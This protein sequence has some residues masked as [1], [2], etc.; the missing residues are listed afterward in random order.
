M[1]DKRI[2][3]RVRARRPL[4]SARRKGRLTVLDFYLPHCD[5]VLRT[6]AVIHARPDDT[7]TWLKRFDFAQL[8]QPVGRAIEGMRAVPRPVAAVA[9]RAR[10]VPSTARFLLDD[11]LRAGFI[12]LSEDRGGHVVLG[13]VGKL[14]KPSLELLPLDREEFL[15]FHE[16]KQVKAVFGFV[17]SRYGAD[18]TQLKHEA[19]FLA[20]DDSARTLFRRFWPVIEPFAGF[21]MQH[22]L[23]SLAVVADEQREAGAPPPPWRQRF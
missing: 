2:G 6:S 3:L 16:A 13:A 18:R 8:C 4:P 15:S 9:Q 19:R 20:T 1:A 14:W 22:A 7:Y 12:L 11:A 23:R 10:A 21:F 17:L 5:A